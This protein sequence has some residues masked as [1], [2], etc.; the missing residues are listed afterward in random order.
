[1]PRRNH[2]SSWARW[3]PLFAA[4]ITM[5]LLNG[6]LLLWRSQQPDS[7][8]ALP[9][10][11]RPVI[12]TGGPL[13]LGPCPAMGPSRLEDPNLVA[14]V[15]SVASS[16]GS[17]D[18][19]AP[20]PTSLYQEICELRVALAEKDAAKAIALFDEE[21]WY[22]AERDYLYDM[23]A[24]HLVMKSRNPV[25]P[26]KMQST[27]VPNQADLGND[28]TAIEARLA[29]DLSAR[30]TTTGLDPAD[31]VLPDGIKEAALEADS[32]DGPEAHA[33]LA[34]YRKLFDRLANALPPEPR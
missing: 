24:L 8:A 19:P 11:G 7:P 12:P 15:D 27:T 2:T 16:T 32:I 4:T 5:V 29:A 14:F 1:M 6:G 20:T 10:I 30:I 22:R 23:L 3:T 34:E 31:F 26:P 9:D 21:P 33:L 25:G 17:L 18:D 28:I 13:T